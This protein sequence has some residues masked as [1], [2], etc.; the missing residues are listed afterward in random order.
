MKKLMFIALASLCGV[1]SAYASGY[2]FDDGSPVNTF[3]IGASAQSD[4]NHGYTSNSRAYTR[5][6]GFGDGSV[7]DSYIIGHAQK[8]GEATHGVLANEAHFGDG[9]PVNHH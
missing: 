7:E 5:A 1:S 4:V 3:V 9:S 8:S 2:A 6:N